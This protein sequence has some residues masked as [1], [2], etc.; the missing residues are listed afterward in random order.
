[1]LVAI[2]LS[3]A[4]AVS[5]MPA[6][7][8]EPT[9]QTAALTGQLER[10]ISEPPDFEEALDHDHAEVHYDEDFVTEHAYVIT[11]SGEQV[12]VP[13][14]SVGGLPT[15]ATVR[16]H[17][18]GVGR[19][20]PRV[21]LL[22]M[23]EA[24]SASRPVRETL[25]MAYAIVNVI[26]PFTSSKGTSVSAVSEV[27]R[28]VADPF[29]R[30]E[31]GNAVTVSVHSEHVV[32]RDDFACNYAAL[33]ARDLWKELR[34]P[35]E[36]GIIMLHH[37]ETKPCSY[38][39]RANVNRGGPE[40]W[41][42]LS[43]TSTRPHQ[44]VPHE[45]GHNLGLTHPAR[46][47]CASG[48]SPL[49]PRASN[50]VRLDYGSRWGIMG[51]A[52]IEPGAGSIEGYHRWQV[53]A[54][55]GSQMLSVGTGE[56]TAILLDNAAPIDTSDSGTPRSLEGIPVVRLLHLRE[57]DSEAW[58]VGRKSVRGSR[59][60]LPGITVSVRADW[61]SGLREDQQS[62]PILLDAVSASDGV[63]LEWS[64][65]AGYDLV[66]VDERI[67]TPGGTVISVLG[68][69]VTPYGD[70]VLITWNGETPA[71]IAPSL[72][73]GER[74]W[75]SGSSQFLEGITGEFEECALVAST[76]AVIA[77]WRAEELL[78]VAGDL[79]RGADDRSTMFQAWS[80]KRNALA[81]ASWRFPLT[82]PLE[83][84][85]EAPSDLSGLPAE[86]TTVLRC[87]D[88]SG[89]SVE[90]APAPVGVDTAAPLLAEGS[91]SLAVEP[92]LVS[93][94]ATLGDARFPV[95]VSVPAYRD[96]AS[97][98]AV[99][100]G[101]CISVP[102]NTAATCLETSQLGSGALTSGARDR[103][104]NVSNLD[105]A[106]G[107][108]LVRPRI[109]PSRQWQL[110]D[111][112]ASGYAVVGYLPQTTRSSTTFTVSG[113]QAGVF[114]KCSGNTG[115]IVVSVNGKRVTTRQLSR[116]NA[117]RCIA[118]SIPLPSGRAK[119]KITY[120]KLSPLVDEDELYGL[121]VLR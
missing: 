49:D 61:K 45:I 96:A 14:S 75:L 43:T 32:R 4:M 69:I 51:G 93:P 37:S 25:N 67:T 23:P 110:R 29:F 85:A 107:L 106:Y 111:A 105:L 26:T 109:K 2:A 8:A 44:L 90:S 30:A 12:E 78:P 99:R 21:E 86:F 72:P 16:V 115:T 83:N 18:R 15:G 89:R 103:A 97:G 79:W 52:I 24:S 104:G 60:G 102:A 114:T 112:S 11:E 3:S 48:T 82:L 27:I 22:S 55:A 76:G 70:G 66:Q 101:A 62:E 5:A 19:S 57:V 84:G 68:T 81:R 74:Q 65:P 58:I 54:Y 36:V 121:V 116:T 28:E 119:V 53:G 88:F 117:S 100:L 98:L 77:R 59:V 118:A 33:L 94:F 56:G 64:T 63:D 35:Y 108:S 40:S 71:P 42:A 113:K 1:M 95:R 120:T 73:A 47:R 7:S 13:L 34:I 50:C 6:V 10:V 92:G 9:G 31:T 80:E 41:I 87:T 38:S 39:G 91:L 20:V 17:T 46:W